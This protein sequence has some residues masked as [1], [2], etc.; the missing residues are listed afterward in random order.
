MTKSIAVDPCNKLGYC[1]YVL[2]YKPYVYMI[3]HPYLPF[4]VMM[5]TIVSCTRD[6]SL[7][8]IIT[9]RS[10]HQ[11]GTPCCSPYHVRNSGVVL[12]SI[13]FGITNPHCM[14]SEAYGTSLCV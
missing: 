1:V 9:M 2:L 13:L 8:Q 6:T 4:L 10:H 3:M 14:H 5:L 12:T 11:C 7:S